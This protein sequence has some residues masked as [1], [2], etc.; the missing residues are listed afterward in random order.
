MQGPSL[1][2]KG[3]GNAF[4]S[5]KPKIDF[6]PDKTTIP[7]PGEY[8]TKPSLSVKKVCKYGSPAFADSA[9]GRVPFDCPPS[10]KIKV[11]PGEYNIEHAEQD[12]YYARKRNNATFLSK[13]PRASQLILHS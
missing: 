11:G 12:P 10:Q 7:G 13:V 5:V 3:Y 1:S 6:V 9:N 8:E 4:L 2:K